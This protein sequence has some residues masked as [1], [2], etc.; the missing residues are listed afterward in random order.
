LLFV[1]LKELP[2]DSPFFVDSSDPQPTA[3]SGIFVAK[4]F[5][6]EVLFIKGLFV[7]RLGPSVKLKHPPGDPLPST[8]EQLRS[9]TLHSI[10]GH[11]V[12]HFA[13]LQTHL[14]NT[15]ASKWIRRRR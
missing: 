6:H 13:T 1:E 11:L 3:G 10:F 4:E 14:L 8:A 5:S 2:S 7:P 9:Q 15:I 12:I